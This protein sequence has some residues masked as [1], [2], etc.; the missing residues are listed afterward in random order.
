MVLRWVAS[1]F[2]QIVAAQV[3]RGQI[4]SR[5]NSVGKGGVGGGG[6]CGGRERGWRGEEVKRES[7]GRGGEEKA[8]GEG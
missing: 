7:W 6:G 3:G 8:E 2:V 4:R 5:P 1:E